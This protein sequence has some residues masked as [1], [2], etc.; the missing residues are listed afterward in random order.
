MKV[1]DCETIDSTY[2]SLEHI[3]GSSRSRLE[4]VLKELDLDQFYR[5]TP[6]HPL[7]P[8]EL[9]SSEVMKVATLPG[10]YDRTCWFHLTRTINTNKFERGILPL[11]QRLEAIWDLLY[12]LARKHVSRGEWIEFRRD[13]GSHH[14]AGVYGMKVNDPRQWGPY[15]LLIRDHAFK[16][17]Q[18]GNHDYFDAPE[19]VEDICICFTEKH[20]FDLLAAFKKITKPCVVKFFDGPRGDC[21]ETAIYHLYQTLWRNQCSMQ[22]NTCYDAEG[23]P[24]PPEWIIK[25]EFPTYRKRRRRGMSDAAASS[26][27]QHIDAMK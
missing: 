2:E 17:E 21:I 18:I 20:G 6:R 12:S 3:L 27:Q 7:P 14:H 10:D 22:C 11:G 8:D 5:D 19:I 26:W 9:V 15:A 13:M 16:S 23:E 25:V 4:S 1:L 24:V